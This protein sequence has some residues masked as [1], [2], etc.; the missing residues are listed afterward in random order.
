LTAFYYSLFSFLLKYSIKAQIIIISTDINWATL[1]G[2]SIKLSVLNPSIKNRPT[3]YNEIY[4]KNISPSILDFFLYNI[5]NMNII[6][7]KIDS[8]KNVGWTFAPSIMIP[9]G[10]SVGLP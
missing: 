6:R 5:K 8:Y 3:E 9:Q 10:R 7:L 1:I 2:P 4:S